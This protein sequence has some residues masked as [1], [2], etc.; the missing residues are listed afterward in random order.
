MSK[1]R[2]RVFGLGMMISLVFC[3]GLTAQDKKAGAFI[4]ISQQG[5]VSYEQMDGSTGPAIAVGKPIPLSYT[6]I[7]GKGGQL[8]G[9][10]SNGTLL[11][12]DE[13][14]RM[15]VGT[16]KQEPFD[17]GGKKLADL[18]GEPSKSEVTLDLDFG[19]LVVKTKKLSKGSAFN[20]NSPVGTAGIRGT[21]FQMASRPGQGVQLDVTESTVAFT[22]PG[23]VP[24]PVSQGNG[25]SV[26]STGVPTMR[27]VNP[28]VARKIE[29]TNQTATEA[30]Q[31]VSLGEVAVAMEQ[32]GQEQEAVEDAPVEETTEESTQEQESTDTQE[33][34]ESES[35]SEPGKEEQESA[36]A[37]E[38]AEE[39]PVTEESAP[40]AEEPKE[41][42]SEPAEQS[43]SAPEEDAS[44]V[45]AEKRE[46]AGV[47]VEEDAPASPAAA[48]S[49]GGKDGKGPARA[50]K[51]DTPNA[52][53]KADSA[54][55]AK[56]PEI[57]AK[58]PPAQSSGNSLPDVGRIVQDNDPGISQERELTKHGL[59]DAQKAQFDGFGPD[60]Q[61]KVKKLETAVVRRLT[62]VKG[63]GDLET[64]AFLELGGKG[65]QSVLGLED[66]LMVSLLR[67]DIDEV[68]RF[69][70]KDGVSNIE[71]GTFLEL[72]SEGRDRVLGLEDSLMVALLQQD[73][74]EVQRFSLKK[75]LGALETEAFL[76]LGGKG[77]DMVLALEDN[78]MV[79][80]LQQDID[81]VQKFTVKDG[82]EELETVAF[83]GLGED[84][85]ELVIGLEDSVMVTLLQQDIDEELLVESLSKMNMDF[86][87]PTDVP[88]FEPVFP[89]DVLD[90]SSQL[91]ELSQKLRDS[92][93]G[94]VMDE[95][96]ELSG[97]ELTE[98][99]LKRGEE[100]VVLLKDYRLE[101]LSAAEAMSAERALSNPFYLEVSALFEELALEGLVS[102]EGDLLGGRHLIIEPNS[103]ALN[104][105]FGDGVEELIVSAS[106]HLEVLAGFEWDVPL[107]TNNAR[108]VLMSGGDLSIAEGATLQSVT[109]DLVIASRNRLVLSGVELHG[110]REVSIRGMRDVQLDNVRMEAS[111]LAKIKARRDLD[112]NGLTFRPD[113]SRIVMEAT[114]MRLRNVTFPA[115]AQVRLNSSLGGIDGR[116]PNFGNVSAAQQIGR[117]NFIE[118]VKS[119]TNLLNSRAAFDQHGGNIQ[120]GKITKP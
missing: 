26:S 112:V 2:N 62:S 66:T 61:A 8:V 39:T 96:Y 110:A 100:A 38:P 117:V 104:P 32:S 40:T 12:L 19:S 118:N 10:L 63:M 6:I 20:I 119:G 64:V 25:L 47:Q 78:V 1:A 29:T 5:S 114:T 23:G 37:D 87:T 71:T 107:E 113:I 56:G 48:P 4:L 97:G 59:S 15:K 13:E 68:R 83:L 90:T 30:T 84:A 67:E 75:G 79:T 91:Q 24:M 7:T 44:P 72:G 93:N 42:K 95:L 14:T 58:A 45:R 94:W 106:D 35:G 55:P 76:E 16:F 108:L 69:T 21:E 70:V 77:R 86:P 54:P 102:G 92:G 51:S 82:V 98:D 18:P 65:R 73:V 101:E 111:T 17:A 81:K 46:E 22:P 60:T 120:I 89:D 105:Y 27:P 31:E 9:L 28:T 74:G 52:S 109:S 11:T 85:R 41:Q 88:T 99:W 53:K 3:T 50:D 43:G 115:T 103:Q 57:P 34:E 33:A 80:L 116:Y 36:P 49:K